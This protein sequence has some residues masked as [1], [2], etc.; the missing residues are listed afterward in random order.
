MSLGKYV[1]SVAAFLTGALL[2]GTVGA[3]SG[4]GGSATCSGTARSVPSW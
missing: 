2:A 1:F 4:G 3:Q